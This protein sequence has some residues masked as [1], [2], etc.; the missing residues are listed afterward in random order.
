MHPAFHH[1][2][3]ELNLCTE[4]VPVAAAQIHPAHDEKQWSIQQVIGHLVMTY[5]STC[6]ILQS[7]LEKGRPLL[8]KP[9]I[10]Q[11]GM[12][13]FVTRFGY[14]PNDL[15]A[16]PTVLPVHAPLTSM[17]GKDLLQTLQRELEAME[18]LLEQCRVQFAKQRVATH[19]ILG[20]LTVEQ[21][22]QFHCVH[23]R[24]HAKQIRRIRAS[25]AA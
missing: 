21:W 4:G 20:P 16:P 5:R 19:I 22:I 23:G 6:A 1:M 10:R 17:G 15:P 9:T 7:R 2:L 24:H 14:F 18:L 12:Q 8:T 25:I 11:R 13:L 3:R